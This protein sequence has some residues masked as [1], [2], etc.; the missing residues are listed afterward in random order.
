MRKAHSKLSMTQT[1]SHDLLNLFITFGYLGIVV[2]MAIES[3]CI[4]LPSE[5]IMPL[6]GFLAFQHHFQLAGAVLAG[7]VGCVIGS[8][9]AYWI[10]AAGGRPLLLKYGRYVFIS[11]HDAERADQYFARYGDATIFITRLLPMVRT[12]ISLPAGIT[13][14]NFAKF[15]TYTFIGSLI[16]SFAL[17]LAGYNLGQHWDTI[18]AFLH[19][20]ELLVGLAIIVALAWFVQ[21]HWDRITGHGGYQGSD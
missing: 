2:A 17:G 9:I 10:G 7:A 14:M 5:L 15:M 21:R 3:C 4:P 1:L 13:H 8:V 20:F 11:A 19:R 6:A 18:G 12:F 16:W